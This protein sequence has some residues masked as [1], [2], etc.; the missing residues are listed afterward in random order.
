MGHNEIKSYLNALV[1]LPISE[2]IR[3][4]NMTWVTLGQSRN[5]NSKNGEVKAIGEFE[6]HIQ[7]PWRMVNT[8]N[9]KCPL[10]EFASADM[11][12]PKNGVAATKEFDWK[13]KDSNLLDEKFFL[14]N[15]KN[16]KPQVTE[17][18]F[19]TLG[20]LRLYL[21]NN[22]ILE[23]FSNNSAEGEYSECWRIFSTSGAKDHLIGMGNKFIFEY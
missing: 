5:T 17:V 14:W 11:F 13:S 7:C 15:K 9:V 8:T 16:D 22:C 6:W 2:M 12:E 23:V 3:T 4:G 21:S 1:G 19:N 20:D 10:I 18:K